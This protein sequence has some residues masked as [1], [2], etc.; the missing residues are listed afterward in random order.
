[1]H[2]HHCPC[3]EDLEDVPMSRYC[4]PIP[5][6]RCEEEHSGCNCAGELHSILGLLE[7]QN[8]LLVDLLGAIN[9]LTAAC[10]CRRT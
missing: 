7:C 10:L 4:N 3:E 9:G 2:E 6:C 5:T 1:M 8:Q